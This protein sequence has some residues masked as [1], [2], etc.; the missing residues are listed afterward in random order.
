MPSSRGSPPPGIEPE[1]LTSPALAGG[2]FTTSTTWEAHLLVLSE[3]LPLPPGVWIFSGEPW[4]YVPRDPSMGA[5]E[6]LRGLVMRPLLR[7]LSSL[8]KQA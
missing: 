4:F 3:L 6:G 8:S 7:T 1:S 2:F 5:P